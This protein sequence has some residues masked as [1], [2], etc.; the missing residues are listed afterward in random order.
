MNIVASWAI[1][2]A[3]LAVKALSMLSGNRNFII[4]DVYHWIYQKRQSDNGRQYRVN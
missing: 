2:V 3:I 1:K 4:Y